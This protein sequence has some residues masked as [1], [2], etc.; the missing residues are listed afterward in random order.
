MSEVHYSIKDLEN[1]TNIK[2]HTIRIWEQRYNILEPLR[3]ETNIRFYLDEHLK[4]LLNVNLLYNSGYKISSIAKLSNEEFIK[5]VKNVIEQDSSSKKE[6]NLIEGILE[7]D[8]K[9]IFNLLQENCEQTG[10]EDVYENIISP[11]LKKI[12]ELWQ[13]NTINVAHEHFYS[14]ILR[15]FIISETL[16]INNPPTKDAVVLFLHE[17]ERH[18]LSLLFTQ[19]LLKANGYHCIYFGQQLPLSDLKSALDKIN[20]T[21]VIS[22]FITQITTD[23]FKEIIDD[24]CEVANPKKLILN[25]FTAVKFKN[26]ISKNIHVLTSTKSLKNI[27]V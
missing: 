11:S 27:F 4:K 25:G 24:I 13:V 3:T 17:N 5:T 22:S 16:K 2:A 23:R 6:K 15:D 14:N 12:G 20:P 26:E 9:K 21:Y 7:F 1:L 10:L 8:S 19:Y 18:E